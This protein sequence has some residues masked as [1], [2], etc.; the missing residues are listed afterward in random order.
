MIVASRGVKTGESPNME[1][2]N[3]I[4]LGEQY[5]ATIDWWREAGVEFQFADEIEPLLLDGEKPVVP[6][7]ALKAEPEAEKPPEP[8][9]ETDALPDT[10]EGF[11]NWWVGPE[12]P[13][14]FGSAPRIAPVGVEGAPIMMLAAMPEVDDHETL[15]AGPQGKLLG[16]ILRAIS[17]DPDT[18]Y[19]AS[20]LPCHTT[21]PDWES[22]GVDGL[23]GV[24][25]RHIALAKPRKILLLGS[26]LP[27]LLGYDV[28]APPESFADIDKTPTLTTFSPDRLLD[29]ARQRARLWKRLCQWNASL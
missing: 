10:L 21:L 6:A 18:A 3:D 12:N 24:L 19:F 27:Q 14:A 4:S 17:V 29:H 23:G 11:R 22:L 9:I 2:R 8:K 26:R 7:A 28:S 5:A 13:F 20:A 16:N 1:N 15:F 25:A